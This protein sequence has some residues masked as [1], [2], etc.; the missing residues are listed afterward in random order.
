MTKIPF[1]GRLF[2]VQP[3]IWLTRSFD[4]VSHSYLG[5]ALGHHGRVRADTTARDLR[6][7]IAGAAQAKHAFQEGDA[8]SGEVGSVP[9]PQ[10][11]SASAIHEP[12]AWHGPAQALTAYRERGHRGLTAKTYETK[13]SSC[14][15]GSCM[16]VFLIKD[17]WKPHVGVKWRYETLYFGPK[18]FALYEAGPTRQAPGRKPGL[19]YVEEDWVDE[20]QTRHRGPRE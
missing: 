14:D 4:Q 10:Q 1:H 5:F 7:G 20:E 13:C 11:N 12:P 16:A 8:I 19:V 17:H 6:V 9:V 15:W 2:S 18:G 3:G